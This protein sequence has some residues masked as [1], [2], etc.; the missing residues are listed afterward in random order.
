VQQLNG[1]AKRSAVRFS[2]YFAALLACVMKKVHHIAS[3]KTK[4]ILNY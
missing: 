1:A 2:S 4:F 3:Q